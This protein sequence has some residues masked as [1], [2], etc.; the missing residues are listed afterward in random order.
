MLLP[1]SIA[2]P[3]TNPKQHTA[4]P[5]TPANELSGA[6][7][8]P[9]QSLLDTP[10]SAK[11]LA[12]A[13]SRGK[14]P[15]GGSLDNP[16]IV[17]SERRDLGE[18]GADRSRRY[19]MRREASRILWHLGAVNDRGY[20]DPPCVA[21]CGM[22]LGEGGTVSILRKKNDEAAPASY[23]GIETCGSVAACPVCSAKIRA[24]RAKEVRKV[25]ENHH[26]TGG[27][28]LFL[29][30]TIP[31]HKGDSLDDCLNTLQSSWRYLQTKSGW[32]GL[33]KD[34]GVLGTV[35]A[36]E[37]LHGAN[38][39]HVH[40]HMLV[41]IEN[42]LSSDEFE[43]F[44]N[45]TFDLWITAVARVWKTPAIAAQN[46]QRVDEKGDVLAQY[47][48]KIQ[49]DTP[50]T[51]GV[52]AEMTRGDLKKNSAGV[53][54]FE[55][56]TADCGY[57]DSERERLFEEYYLATKGR[58]VLTWS[59]GVKAMYLEPDEEASEP[60]DDVEVLWMTKSKDYLRLQARPDGGLLLARALSLAENGHWPE[61][62]E[63]LPPPAS[64]ALRRGRSNPS[65]SSL[66]KRYTNLNS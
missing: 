56:L 5:P 17:L 16:G 65:S 62:A 15:H 40:S 20:F 41:L 18:Y 9:K 63:L 7:C 52:D 28:A 47:L 50:K 25:V 61:L 30:L 26:R 64:P 12:E 27:E 66:S 35:K 3:R 46:L 21:S 33:K 24:E 53:L 54:P 34:L 58:R 49:D 37:I 13:E 43:R 59:K 10:A 48:T 55:L 4:N 39:W 11:R 31:H 42:K 22:P 2:T 19:Q 1:K 8:T 60:D 51:W 23:T 57:S 44:K 14:D 29:T 6:G 45:T 36:V 32:R 38:G